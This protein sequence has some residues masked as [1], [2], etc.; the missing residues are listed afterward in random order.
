MASDLSIAS[1]SITQPSKL[2]G[3]KQ[4]LKSSCHETVQVSTCSAPGFGNARNMHTGEP[5]YAC[6]NTRSKYLW[7]SDYK[8]H[9]CFGYKPLQ[10][11]YHTLLVHP[12]PSIAL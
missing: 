7:Q 9:P 2:K 6:F 4:Y 12:C 5:K 11:C 10:W 8:L 3:E 1:F